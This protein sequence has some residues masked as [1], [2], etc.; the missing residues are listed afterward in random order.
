MD[1]EARRERI[2]RAMADFFKTHKPQPS[3]QPQFDFKSSAPARSSAPRT[4][5]A[6]TM[7]TVAECEPA[8]STAG[9]FL[10]IHNSYIV[11]Q[12]DEGFVIVDQHALHERIIYEDLCRKISDG[13]LA[14]QRLL[15]PETIEVNDAQAD[16]I[17]SHAELIAKLGIEIA[18]FG[19]QTFAIHAFPAILPKVGPLEFVR[20]L[21]DMLTDKSLNLDTERLL[22]EVLDMA[23]CKAAIKAGQ[24]LTR[25][26]M[27]QLLAD[28]KTVDRA[29]HCPHGR[30]TTIK[31]TIGELEKQFKRT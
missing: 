23:A 16:A 8:E 12:T 4:A 9:E 27:A 11:T 24:A 10:Q 20:D 22:H 13:P 5:S 17:Q 31:F 14:S 15:I 7:P 21:L 19:P 25:T 28:K 6:F 18:P 1:D 30:P 29:S 3:S 2:T 26:E